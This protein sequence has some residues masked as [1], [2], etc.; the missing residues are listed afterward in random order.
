[1]DFESW[2]RSNFKAKSQTVKVEAEEIEMLPEVEE[3][4]DGPE[5][6]AQVKAEVA[7]VILG[8]DELI[9]NVLIAIIAGGHILLE[10][11]PGVGK[12]Q[13]ALAFSKSLSLTCNRV[14]FTPDITSAEILGYN[15]MD[16]GRV[17]HKD[18]VGVTCNI[19]LADEINRT[20]PKTQSAFLE[21]MAEKHIT[22][23]G[24]TYKLA[25]PYTVIAT[26]NPFGGIGTNELPECQ[27][28]R[29][30]ARLSIGMPDRD[31][32]VQILK[33]RMNGENPLDDIKPVITKEQL[34]NIIK[35][36]SDIKIYDD[37]YNFT[38]DKIQFIRNNGSP[39]PRGSL[40]LIKAAM[41]RAYMEG[42]DYVKPEDIERVWDMVLLHRKY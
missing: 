19:F 38:V 8:K 34:V 9:E 42:R 17:I 30:L 27:L 14:Q 4:I 25:N 31:S 26:Q 3:I 39:S 23:D 29:F 36:V 21:L 5:R 28:D 41:A 12:T 11:V 16:G 18:G 24:K 10:D 7:K 40:Y 15:Y 1:M 22:I 2:E 35:A 6:L 33:D 32:E 13:L 20:S 37:I